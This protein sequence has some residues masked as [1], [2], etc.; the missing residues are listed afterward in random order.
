MCDRCACARGLQSSG[1]GLCDRVQVI[2]FRMQDLCDRTQ[3]TGGPGSA[4]KIG[5]FIE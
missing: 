1:Q 2:G 3:V 5:P 4:L